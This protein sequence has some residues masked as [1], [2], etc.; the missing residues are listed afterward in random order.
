MNCD[1]Q[2]EST[3]ERGWTRYQCAREGCGK[4]SAYTPDPPKKWK[5]QPRCRLSADDPQQ[6]PVAGNCQHLGEV[7]RLQECPTCTG[8]VQVKIFTCAVYDEC[9]LAKPLP[10]IQ[11]CA[12]CP[13][14]KPLA[15]GHLAVEPPSANPSADKPAQSDEERD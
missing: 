9:S 13:R 7:S 12:N 14:Y 10:G 4:L 11:T 8:K 5:G 6:Q 1:W 2:Q 15:G 3:N